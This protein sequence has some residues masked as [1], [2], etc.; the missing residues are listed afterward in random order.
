MGVNVLLSLIFQPDMIL[1]KRTIK[2]IFFEELNKSNSL[3]W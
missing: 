1:E 2:L 3:I